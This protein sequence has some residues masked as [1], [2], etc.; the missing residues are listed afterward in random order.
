MKITFAVFGSTGDV[1]PFIALGNA[2]IKKGHQVVIA[3]HRSFEETIKGIG[4]DFS[5]FEGN[6]QE[7]LDG[8]RGKKWIKAGNRYY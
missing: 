8:N 2:L 4:A 3:T 5:L 6:P 7:M 1:Q